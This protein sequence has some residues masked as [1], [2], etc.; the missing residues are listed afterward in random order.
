MARTPLA[1]LVEQAF[2]APRGRSP[3]NGGRP[4]PSCSATPGSSA[5][6]SPAPARSQAGPRRAR[7]RAASSSSAP[8]SP[9]SPPRTASA[10]RASSPRSTRPRRASA[11]AAGP[12][13]D[14]WD[15]GQIAERGGEL[16][17]QG[18][19]RDPPAR[20]GARPPARQPARGRGERDASRPTGSTARAT[21][22]SDA[23]RDLK[24]GLA[25]DPQGR[26]RRRASRRPT[27][28]PPQRG[29]ELDAMS[30]VDWIEETVPGRHLVAVGQLLDVAY[31]I[32]YGAE[33]SEQSSLNLLYLLGYAGPGEPPDL[34]QVEREV[35]RAR[36]Q[37]PDPVAPRGGLLAG[38][39]TTGSELVGDPA[40]GG[41]PLGA[42]VP[43]GL[44]ARRRSPPTG[45]CWRSRSRSC[46][47]RSTSVAPASAR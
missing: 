7:R 29:R 11:G 28:S 43:A 24:A 8:A 36:R 15:D 42:D 9:A 19:T 22:T 2:S 31:T 17:D 12:I 35:P 16:I 47:A 41:R 37:R 14:D 30:I 4:V 40:D 34:R 27:P 21:R 26:R 10:R 20:P 1:A 3:R 18:H 33:S 32:E 13:R 25:E 39:I 44:G 45:S 46:A 6:R 38:Q 23:T 5:S